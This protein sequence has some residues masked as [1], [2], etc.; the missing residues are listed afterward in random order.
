[1]GP[2]NTRVLADILVVA[3]LRYALPRYAKRERY[4]KIE[5]LHEYSQ[6]LAIRFK[7][8]LTGSNK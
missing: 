4:T 2:P 8:N 6:I 3:S 7:P 1:M 5:D